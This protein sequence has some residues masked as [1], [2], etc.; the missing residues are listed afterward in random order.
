MQ[1]NQTTNSIVIA[2]KESNLLQTIR[3]SAQLCDSNQHSRAKMGKAKKNFILNGL[4]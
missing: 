1:N 3:F 2:T 4:S